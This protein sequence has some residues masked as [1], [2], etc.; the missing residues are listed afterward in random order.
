ML[1]LQKYVRVVE[2]LILQLFSIP[3]KRSIKAVCSIELW[4]FSTTLLKNS[5]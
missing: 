2:K 3:W 1:K 4:N 5:F